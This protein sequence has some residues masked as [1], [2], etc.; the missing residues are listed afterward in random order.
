MYKRNQVDGFFILHRG[1][2]G[3]GA[4]SRRCTKA[5]HLIKRRIFLMNGFPLNFPCVL[6]ALRCVRKFSAKKVAGS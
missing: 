6:C 4:A 3:K 5:A 1:S 2:R